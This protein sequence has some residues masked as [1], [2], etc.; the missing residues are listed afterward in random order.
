[1]MIRRSTM[2]P[3][4]RAL[5]NFLRANGPTSIAGLC[6]AFPEF[7]KQVLSRRLHNMRGI[8]WLHAEG[9]R[10]ALVWSMH[11]D[12]EHLLPALDA[13]LLVSSMRA[14]IQAKPVH[15]PLPAGPK[16]IDKHLV[17][18]SRSYEFR[19]WVASRPMALR[20]GSMDFRACPSRG[21][22]C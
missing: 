14:P 22:R 21:V 15:K 12:S 7:D 13:G 2:T 19:P 16:P 18:Q 6:Q 5:V 9:A 3:E 10:G 11:P 1:M 20:A 17:A 4:S 8:G